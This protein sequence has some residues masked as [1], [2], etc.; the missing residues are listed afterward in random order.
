MVQKHTHISTEQNKEPKNKPM[1]ILIHD[2]G[3]K[4]INTM[5]KG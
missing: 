4:N 3:A 1:F 5:E 2:E